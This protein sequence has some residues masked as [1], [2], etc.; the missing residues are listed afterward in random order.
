[1]HDPFRRPPRG[2]TWE[3][4][5]VT[6]GNGHYGNTG[7]RRPGVAS[8]R[9]NDCK[10]DAQS[11]ERRGSSPPK[12]ASRRGQAPPL[13]W[14]G[15]TLAVLLGA[16]TLAVAQAPRPQRPREMLQS[17]IEAYKHDDYESAAVLFA[18]ARIGADELDNAERADLDR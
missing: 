4:L 10:N 16:S 12:T 6:R 18:K 3:M 17:A 2:T 9:A 8:N 15:F 1:H 11:T 5:A 13:A 14:L 7:T